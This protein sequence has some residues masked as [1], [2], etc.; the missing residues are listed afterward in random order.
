MFKPKLLTRDAFREGTLARFGGKCAF[1]DKEALDAHHII[2]RRLWSDGGYYLENGAGVCDVHHLD[3]EMTKISV[4]DVRVACGIKAIVLPS[5]LYADQ[6]YDK[7]GNPILANGQRT[8]GEL[9]YDESVQ[10][11]LA[12]GGALEL[13]THHVKYGRTHHLAFSPGVNDDDRVIRNME[14]FKGKRVILSEKMDGENTSM[15]TDHYHARSVESRNHPS[16]SWCKAFWGRI[17]GDIPPLWRVCGE[18]LFAQHSIAYSDLDSYFMGFSVWNERNM[19]LSWDE[20]LEW[21]ELLGIVPVPVLYDG[22][23]DEEK[24]KDICKNKDW[25]TSEGGVLRI[26]DSFSYSDFSHAIAKYVRANHV[27]TN[28]HWMQGQAVTPNGLRSS[29]KPSL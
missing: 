23:Y 4:E 9:F 17:S 12:L 19:C 1:C 28:K 21:F 25:H 26:A 11:I 22:I 5:H 27:Q 20:T 8:R 13:F 15:Y 6:V 2:E 10:K 16:R 7:W 24:I 18:N 3:C 29:R 14:A